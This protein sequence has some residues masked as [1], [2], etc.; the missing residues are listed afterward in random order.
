MIDFLQPLVGGAMIGASAAGLLLVNGKIAGISGILSAATSHRSEAWQW[1]F[2]LGLVATGIGSTFVGVHPPAGLE[3]QGLMLLA[4]AGLLVGVGTRLCGGCTSGHGVCG[5]A[6]LSPRSL[7]ATV[8]FMVV[9]GLTVFATHHVEP[10]R[11]LLA[12]LARP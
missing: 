3:H 4:G 12:G 11:S 2:L 7:T 6:N 9:A 5:L 8:A 10:V 1:T